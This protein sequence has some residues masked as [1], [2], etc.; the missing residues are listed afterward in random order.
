MLKILLAGLI[1]L[2][3]IL[4]PTAVGQARADER[5]VV[6]LEAPA[7]PPVA[8]VETIVV[9]P[10]YLWSHGHW[11]WNSAHWVWIPGH[12][13]RVV[14]NRTYIHPHYLVRG[15]RWIFIRGHWV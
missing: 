12:Y 13:V 11:Y 1:G 14:Y 7:A 6:V 2:G 15:H 9:R 4:G 10:G 5:V 8:R 3:C